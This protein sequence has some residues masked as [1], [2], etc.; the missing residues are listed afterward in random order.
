MSAANRIRTV[1]RICL[2]TEDYKIRKTGSRGSISTSYGSIRH[3]QDGDIDALVKYA[4]NRN[5][6]ANLRD[7][8]PHPYTCEHARSFLDLVK[9][10]NPVTYYAIATHKEAIGSIG[11]TLNEDVHRLTA[12]T[13]YWLA[14]PYWG[15]GIMTETVIRFYMQK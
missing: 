7:A 6:S 10:Q 12:E 2:R 15:E 3:W 4:N 8:F 1:S 13:G 14:Q 5:I 11:I 9:G